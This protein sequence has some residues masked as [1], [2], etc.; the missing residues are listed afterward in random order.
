MV[1][2]KGIQRASSVCTLLNTSSFFK[3]K[4]CPTREIQ[5]VS[6]NES[7]QKAVYLSWV[8]F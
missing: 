2:S 5:G 6:G 4:L 1:E 3:S 8:K 7:H